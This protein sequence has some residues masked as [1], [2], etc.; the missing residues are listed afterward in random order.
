MCVFYEVES[1]STSLGTHVCVL[2]WV[3]FLRQIN[4]CI[5]VFHSLCVCL[6]VHRRA[7]VYTVCVT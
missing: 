6:L 5:C 2:L 4:V 7:Q 1:L 3:S